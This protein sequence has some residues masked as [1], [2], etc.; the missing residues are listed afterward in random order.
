VPTNDSPPT[1]GAPSPAHQRLFAMAPLKGAI[2]KPSPSNYAGPASGGVYYDSDFGND[3]F[4]QLWGPTGRND[5]A[6]LKAAG[7]NFIHL[8]DWNQPGSGRNHRAFLDSAKANGISL[9]VPISMYYVNE[10]RA[11]NPNIS[12]WMNSFL[13]EVYPGKERHP[14]VVMWSIGNEFDNNSGLSADDIARAAKAV[15]AAEDRLGIPEAERVAITS[16]VTF[17]I[18]A[19]SPVE[20]AGATLQI[21]AAFERQGLGAV[22]KNRYVAAVNFFKTPSEISSWVSTRFPLAVPNTPF[23]LFEFG[24]PIGAAAPTE[25]AQGTYY[26]NLL[27]A[28]KPNWRKGNFLGQCVFSYVNEAWKSGPGETTY[29]VY[30]IAKANASTGRT[31]GG[32]TYPIDQ[33]AEKPSFTAMKNVY[34]A[35]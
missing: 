8:Y 6:K 30:R 22:W 31:T 26:A 14:A 19:P 29:G 7:V 25:A 20:G 17:G 18:F 33:L 11:N 12:T 35:K 10:V 1:G 27:N 34:L 28:V 3:D 15:V 4:K 9:N 21:K 5:L 16:P 24:Q 32:Q 23:M 2:Y 13:S